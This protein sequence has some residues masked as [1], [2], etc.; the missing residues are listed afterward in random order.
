MK[1]V[2]AGTPDFAAVALRALIDAGHEV[3]LA[4]SQPDRPSGR[5]MQLHASP[6]KALATELGIPV[7]Q[8][9]GL[10]IGGKYDADARAAHDL[11]CATPHD[12]MVV[13]AY[14]LIIPPA[15]LTI[16]P[17]GCI[18]I[19]ASLL[20]RWRGAAP[21]QRAIEAGD[22]ETGIT[23]MQMDEGLD[24]GAMLLVR[25][26]PITPTATGASLTQELAM[27]GGE[28]IVAALPLIES[29]QLI[30]RPQ[31][32]PGAASG[33]TYAAKLVKS[34]GQLDFSLP[35]RRLVDRIRAFD[36]WPGCQAALVDERTGTSVS[37]KVWKA[38]A[39]A[40][41]AGR[42]P[43]RVLDVRVAG[44]AGIVVATGD[45]VIVLTELQKPGGKRLAARL[46]LPDFASFEDLR[47]LP[48]GD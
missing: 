39:S 11:L 42:E 10:R 26:W 14:G 12:A 33:V 47:F 43:G 18:N 32:P 25:R 45:G 4:L 41:T 23:I 24:T 31:H 13:A 17:H 16:A 22:R 40:S 8:P 34:E 21:V 44:E 38:E 46:F 36:P 28:A 1:L 15:L 30:G 35:A 6:V 2:F 5:G 27:L 19:H 48:I 20:P 29:G 7:V 3:V 9:R 37:F